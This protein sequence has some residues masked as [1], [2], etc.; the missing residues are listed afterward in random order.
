MESDR[1]RTG[2]SKLPQIHPDRDPKPADGELIEV[3]PEVPRPV[4]VSGCWIKDARVVTCKDC[5]R[6][7]E[8]ELPEKE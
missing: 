2:V 6:Y 8:C 1:M 3:K 4:N 5:C 7:E